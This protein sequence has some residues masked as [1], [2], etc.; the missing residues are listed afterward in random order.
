MRMNKVIRSDGRIPIIK[1]L[2]SPLRKMYFPK[3]FAFVGDNSNG[4]DTPISC[5]YT[6]DPRAVSLIEGMGVVPIDRIDEIHGPNNR[7]KSLVLRHHESLSKALG[8][9]D[10]IEDLTN[11]PDRAQLFMTRGGVFTLM[12]RPT[13]WDWPSPMIFYIAET[14]DEDTRRFEV[15]VGSDGKARATDLL[16][17]G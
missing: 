12:Q 10:G 16:G 1:E 7:A 11:T 3:F 4:D 17:N 14:R 5:L 6:L 15:A 8:Y 13:Q 9:V 2:W